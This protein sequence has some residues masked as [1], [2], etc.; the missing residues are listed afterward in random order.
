MTDPTADDIRTRPLREIAEPR[1]YLA[2]NAPRSVPCPR[3]LVLRLPPIMT[4]YRSMG[5]PL[6]A[7]FKVVCVE[8]ENEVAESERYLDRPLP[9][10][11]VAFSLL[12]SVDS[13]SI[14]PSTYRI[15]E[16]GMMHYIAGEPGWPAY[17]VTSLPDAALDPREFQ[18]GRYG[19]DA[20]ATDAE[21]I[22]H[23]GRLMASMPRKMRV[24]V[25]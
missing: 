3:L 25:F 23:V 9:W 13:I 19:F 18:R 22:Q 17:V 12:E 4:G 24:R 2:Q 11:G 15:K 10:T 16:L 20:F 7:R 8:S 14:R 21:A 5:R 6:N 1:W